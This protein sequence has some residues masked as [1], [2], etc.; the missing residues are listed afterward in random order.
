MQ[1][2]SITRSLRLALLAL[3]V[4]LAVVAAVGVSSLYRSRQRY[5]DTLL[6]SSALS[7]AAANLVSAG[8]T[9]EEVIRDTRGAHAAAARRQAADQYR[10]AASSVASLAGSDPIS[11]RLIRQQTAAQTRARQLSATGKPQL[12][13]AAQGQIA[14]ARGLATE[15]QARQRQRQRTARDRARSDSRRAIVLVAVAGVLALLAALALITALVSSMRRPLDELVG[16]TRALA[17]GDLERR[18]TPT[19]PRELRELGTSFNAMADDLVSA[20]RRIDAERSRL[21]VTVESL[22]DALIVT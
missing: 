17:G 22:G 18:V 9:E 19:G 5:E 3:T 11:A 15:L 21:A 7:T 12:A 16:A 13:T 2:L 6:Q 14:R 8:I 4:V 10:N 1:R 20:Q